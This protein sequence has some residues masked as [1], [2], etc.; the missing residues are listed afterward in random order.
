MVNM[1]GFKNWK[2][3]NKIALWGIIIP[4]IVAILLK[5]GTI[6]FGSPDLKGYALIEK[7]STHFFKKDEELSKMNKVL[8][9]KN[10]EINKLKNQLR[11]EEL[12]RKEIALM[13]RRAASVELIKDLKNLEEG[14]NLLKKSV[15]LDP[16]E[17]SGWKQLGHVLYLLKRY[18]EAIITYENVVNIARAC[19]DD[20]LQASSRYNQM[21]ICKTQ[22]K[23]EEA[24]N[25]GK[26]ARLI[27]I[28]IHM[29]TQ[30]DQINSQ[31]NEM[32]SY[33]KN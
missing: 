20:Q 7:L 14:Y 15:E 9:Q 1:M 16:Q 25:Y 32:Y 3:E 21:I 30:S 18:D 33:S 19:S 2:I 29:N 13:F 22:G 28:N 4:A 12:N 17:P 8:H 23:I 6:A 27:Y 10:D 5:A 26:K 24:I 31:I 11:T